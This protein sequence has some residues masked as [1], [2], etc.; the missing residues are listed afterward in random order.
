ML[1]PLV[2]AIFFCVLAL[3]QML[4]NVH[5]QR[6]I[7]TCIY[8]LLLIRFVKP[9]HLAFKQLSNLQAVL[10]MPIAV[11]DVLRSNRLDIQ[12]D[13]LAAAAIVVGG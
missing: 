1:P 6:F 7:V 4:Y 10:E 13:K 8:A 2:I 11:F 3:H 9:L 12:T 5:L